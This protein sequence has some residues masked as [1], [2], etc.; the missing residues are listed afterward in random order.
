MISFAFVLV[1]NCQYGILKISS[2]KTMPS[3]FCI[4]LT[5]YS[6][7]WRRGFCV[8]IT[9]FFLVGKIR[10]GDNVWLIEYSNATIDYFLNNVSSKCY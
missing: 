6:C 10:F 9:F 4:L 3:C 7:S 2:Y 1:P 5:T 8:G